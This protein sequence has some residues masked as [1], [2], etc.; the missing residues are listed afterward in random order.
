MKNLFKIFQ[1]ILLVAIWSGAMAQSRP[2]NTLGNV[3]KADAA[4]AGTINKQMMNP[5][6]TD[7][8]P[9]VLYNN[10][11]VYNSAGT[12]AGGANESVIQSGLLNYG[13]GCQYAL[14]L[15]VADDFIVPAGFAWTINSFSFY[16]Y[17]TGSGLNSTINGIAVL[18]WNGKPGEVGSSIVWG[19]WNNNL[20]ASGAFSGIY[21]TNIVNGGSTRPLMKIEANTAG[22][23]LQPGTYWVEWAMTGTLGSGPWCPPLVPGTLATGNAVQTQ[24]GATYYDLADNG[25]AVG[26]PFIVNGT[27]QQMIPTLSEWGLILLGLALLGFGTFYI[28]RMKNA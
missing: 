27:S 1:V 25:Y 26:L 14:G 10:G 2:A 20:L 8:P 12:H 21:R 23:I 16:T 4:V 17:Q 15:S 5:V 3:A 18:I 24:D 11:P 9:T 13:F 7:D 28:L 22:L 19:D 6:L